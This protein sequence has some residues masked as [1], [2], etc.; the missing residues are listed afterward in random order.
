MNV[1]PMPAPMAV[2]AWH[3][4]RFEPVSPEQLLLTPT[5]PLTSQR[6][7]RRLKTA[8][9]HVA[10]RQRGRNRRFLAC[11]LGGVWMAMVS[12]SQAQFVDT[13]AQ[14][15]REP[16]PVAGVGAL[17]AFLPGNSGAR[18]HSA[19]KSECLLCEKQPLSKR[20]DSVSRHLYGNVPYSGTLEFRSACLRRFVT[21]FALQE[22]RPYD[23]AARKL[24]SRQ[25]PWGSSLVASAAP[26]LVEGSGTPMCA[27]VTTCMTSRCAS[28]G[29]GHDPADRRPETDR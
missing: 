24:V 25:P 11:G 21:A 27:S 26:C 29:C 8:S 23:G 3:A 1:T 9:A 12:L 16:L 28:T 14:H 19:S 10:F 17:F 6:S 2:P 18:R 5:I 15:L 4:E 13:D 7:A 22:R 20:A